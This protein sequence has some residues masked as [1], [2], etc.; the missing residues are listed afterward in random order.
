MRRGRPCQPDVRYWS[1]VQSGHAI[2]GHLSG[3]KREGWFT[4]LTGSPI[5]GNIITSINPVAQKA[6]ALYNVDPNRPGVPNFV[7]NRPGS[8]FDHIFQT[9]VDQSFG[10]SDQLFGRYMFGQDNQVSPGALP[11]AGSAIRFRGQNATLGWTHTFGPTLLQ[12]VRVGFQRNTNVSS[13]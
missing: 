7:S 5:P 6:L 3:R 10:P 1:T 11:F 4:I 8:R 9:R 13:C 2:A 12:D